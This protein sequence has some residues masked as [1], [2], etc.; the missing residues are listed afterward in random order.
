[1]RQGGQGQMEGCWRC[2]GNRNGLGEQKGIAE[3]GGVGRTCRRSIGDWYLTGLQVAPFVPSTPMFTTHAPSDSVTCAIHLAPRSIHHAHLC[4]H[5][6]PH[7]HPSHPHPSNH[8]HSR[9]HH[10]TADHH[11]P[12]LPTY[13]LT[14]TFLTYS[15]RTISLT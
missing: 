7:W 11:A 5:P 15:S 2:D 6:R 12:S 10:S 14:C 9:S 13:P 8:L 3:D 1:M 4:S